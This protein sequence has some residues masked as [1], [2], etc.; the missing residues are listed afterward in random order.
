MT[1]LEEQTAKLSLDSPRNFNLVYGFAS[2]KGKR[3]R[4]E[5]THVTL[6]SLPD[7]PSTAFFA[8][9]NPFFSFH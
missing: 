6:A 9:R 4:N 5:D 7:D 3:D 2:L 1:T 8:G